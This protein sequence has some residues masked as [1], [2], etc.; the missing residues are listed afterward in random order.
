M[1]ITE[2][3]RKHVLHAALYRSIYN[4]YI[5]TYWSNVSFKTGEHSQVR[6]QHDIAYITGM[7]NRTQLD[8]DITVDSVLLALC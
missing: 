3:R 2:V 1:A 7:A 6:L 8:L 5:K 4:I